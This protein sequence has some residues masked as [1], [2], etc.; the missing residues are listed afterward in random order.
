MPKAKKSERLEPTTDDTKAAKRDK[1]K[2][3]SGMRETG[4]DWKHLDILLSYGASKVD[5]AELL[6]CSDDTIER[7]INA[8]L[9][10]QFKEYRERKLSK[11]RMR[12][13]KGALAMAIE[14]GNPTMM[15][16]C[17]K[18]FCKWSDS[19]E[20]KIEGGEN[21]VKVEDTSA[22]ALEQSISRIAGLIADLKAS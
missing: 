9:G 18:H 4:F 12:L 5:C 16:F 10:I 17:L 22:A 19:T 3:G 21:P 8:K 1:K 15:I 2:P 13:V 11:T 6:D 7:R 14:G 20:I